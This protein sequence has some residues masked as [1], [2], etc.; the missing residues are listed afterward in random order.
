MK[1]GYCY[2]T[3]KILNINNGICDAE[4]NT[5]QCDWDGGDC[6]TSSRATEKSYNNL[7]RSML[8]F[9]ASV[10]YTATV[11]NK[12]FGSV[13]RQVPAHVPY[14][15]DRSLMNELQERFNMIFLIVVE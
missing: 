10:I 3:C 11:Y 8:P 5:K 13:D 4:C 14:I 12:A 9:R 6:Q 2:K 15:I 7:L 1:L